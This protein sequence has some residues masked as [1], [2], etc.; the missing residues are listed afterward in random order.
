MVT[1]SW[2]HFVVLYH[3]SYLS[4]CHHEVCIYACNLVHSWKKFG[5]S[6]LKLRIIKWL[7]VKDIKQIPTLFYQNKSVPDSKSLFQRAWFLR[8]W[9]VLHYL[10][11]WPLTSFCYHW[12]LL[13]L[14]RFGVLYRLHN[15]VKVEKTNFELQRCLGMV[16][17][18]IFFY[19]FLPVSGRHVDGAGHF[20]YCHFWAHYAALGRCQD[21]WS[22]WHPKGQSTLQ[23]STEMW[24]T[25]DI[26]GWCFK[27]SNPNNRK[28]KLTLWWML[29]SD[30]WLSVMMCAHVLQIFFIGLLQAVLWL[31]S[32]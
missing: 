20:T 15:D 1:V 26:K 8:Y 22:W 25:A 16:H 2:I 27:V 7:I 24:V 18:I 14:W 21:N 31:V 6:C 17:P 32:C 12:I 13:H 30:I 3:L 28:C 19:F 29:D 23:R 4:V 11:G 10:S 9:G 5:C